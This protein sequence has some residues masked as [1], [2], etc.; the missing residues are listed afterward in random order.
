MSS[1]WYCVND[2]RVPDSQEY[3][4]ECEPSRADLDEQYKKDLMLLIRGQ[5]SL[6]AKLNVAVKAL[7]RIAAPFSDIDPTNDNRGV[8]AEALEQI[9]ATERSPACDCHKHDKQVCDICQG[10]AG[11]Q[12]ARRETE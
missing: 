3:C 5:E 2:H 10:A 4:D 8:A 9:R 11:R 6:Q 12:A 7:E 1:V